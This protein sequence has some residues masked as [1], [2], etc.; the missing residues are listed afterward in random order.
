MANNWA[1]ILNKQL[2]LY[3]AV[4]SESGLSFLKSEEDL[5]RTDLTKAQALQ[6]ANAMNA[7]L[8]R[9]KEIL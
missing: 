5:I 6:K 7:M 9:A 8:D 1:V 4:S 3:I 2:W